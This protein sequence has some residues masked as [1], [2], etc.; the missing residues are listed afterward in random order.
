MYMHEKKFL[1]YD[2]EKCENH[3]CNIYVYIRGTKLYSMEI[4]E[5]AFLSSE[6]DERIR[7]WVKIW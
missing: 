2:R 1:R 4:S 5:N 6:N 3:C 7:S